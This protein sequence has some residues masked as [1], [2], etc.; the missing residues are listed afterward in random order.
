[1]AMSKSVL[2]KHYLRA[3]SR[4][5]TDPLRPETQ[6]SEAIRR[7]I[8]KTFSP[9]SS[10]ALNGGFTN[11]AVGKAGQ[12]DAVDITGMKNIVALNAGRE[13]E[14]VNALYSLLEGRYGRKYQPLSKL[15]KPTSNPTYYT[16][17]IAELEA[18]PTRGFWDSLL[19]R[20]KGFLRF[21]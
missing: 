14:Q 12:L 16:D 18:A 3:I 20:W 9:A 2:Q 17:L 1:M 10:S 7:R 21:K 11:E 19:N 6:F 5:P 15:L 4:W 13:A 8:D